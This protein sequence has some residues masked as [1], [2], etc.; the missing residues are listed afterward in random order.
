LVPT[1]LL[2]VSWPTFCSLPDR[3]QG[4]QFGIHR[5]EQGAHTLA[6]AVAISISAL[7]ELHDAHVDQVTT[8][9]TQRCMLFTLVAIKNS[10]NF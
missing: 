8:T 9:V 10:R 2:A 7:G 1:P 5:M 6:Q 4:G 3:A